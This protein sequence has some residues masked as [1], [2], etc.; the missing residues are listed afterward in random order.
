[1]ARAQHV[2]SLCLSVLCLL[3]CVCSPLP[4][5]PHP[6]SPPSLAAPPPD[7]DI[8]AILQ[9]GERETKDLNDKMN[10]FTDNARQFTMD[11]GVSLYDYKEEVRGGG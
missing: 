3:L 9:K 5:L 7:A 8:E 11:G 1:M 4:L 10:K 6:P 2:C